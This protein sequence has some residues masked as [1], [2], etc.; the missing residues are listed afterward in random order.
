[1]KIELTLPALERLIGDDKE[2]ELHLREQIVN[3]FARRHLKEI[4]K[5]ESYEAA[6]KEVKDYV[7]QIARETFDIENLT[8]N[9]VWPTV[10]YRIRTLIEDLVKEHAQKAVDAALQKIIEY[11]KRYWAEEIRKAVD[12]AINIE[13]DK[14][15]TEGIMKRL[16]AAIEQT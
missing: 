10:G 6:I 11:Q 15:V 7:N 2:I 1:M 16:K 13:I 3:E 14:Q 9:T 4:A 12:G 5:T 8:T